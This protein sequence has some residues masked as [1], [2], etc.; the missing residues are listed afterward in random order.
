LVR[1]KRWFLAV[2]AG[3]FLLDN[4]TPAEEVLGAV[5]NPA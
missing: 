1:K 2:D 3:T 4:K 5:L